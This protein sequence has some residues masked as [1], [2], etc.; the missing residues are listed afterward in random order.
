MNGSTTRRTLLGT[1]LA[2]TTLA[3]TPTAVFAQDDGGDG[4]W[5]GASSE[6]GW[7]VLE[8]ASAFAVEG[9][10]VA[11]ECAPGYP[12]EVMLYF[13]RRF[14]SEVI[15]FERPAD[16]RGF[17]K[18][19]ESAA[20]FESNYFSG[21]AFEVFP[22][23]FGIGS[24]ES[25]FPHQITAVRAILNDLGGALLWGGDLAPAKTSHFHLASAAVPEEPLEELQALPAD[26]GDLSLSRADHLGLYPD[27]KF[28][29]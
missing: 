26:D 14:H 18:R 24:P 11:L 5:E 12:A 25:L 15:P 22:E 4:R 23:V 28:G 29:E 7:P 19:G 17:R 21:T 1:T 10:P 2:A 9:T 3:A 20:S 27:L 6:N 13:L 8:E 16:V